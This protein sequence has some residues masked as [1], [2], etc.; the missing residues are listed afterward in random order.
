LFDATFARHARGTTISIRRWPA[1]SELRQAIADKVATL[2]GADYDAEREITVTA[3]ATQAVFTAIAA[4]VRQD[5]E[6]IVFE[7]VYDS[8]VPAIETVGGKAVYATLASRTYRPDWQ[9]VRS[10]LSPRTR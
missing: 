1:W 6:V 2:Y 3:G 8:Y 5:D 9:Q 4:F 10:L 7:P